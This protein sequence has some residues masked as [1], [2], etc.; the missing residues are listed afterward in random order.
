MINPFFKVK[1][2][3]KNKI[4]V[5]KIY[6]S[7]HYKDHDD[8]ETP[9]KHLSVVFIVSVVVDYFNMGIKSVI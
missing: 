7:K 9:N 1:S 4:N 3:W 8:I 2:D 6:E 5:Q